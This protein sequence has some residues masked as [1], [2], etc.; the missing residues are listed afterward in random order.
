MNRIGRNIRRLREENGFS[1]E[2]IAFELGLTQTSYARLE[3]ADDRI[4]ITR[5]FKIAEVLNVCIHSLINDE[6][7]A[8]SDNDKE[9]ISL[10]KEE[11]AFLRKLIITDRT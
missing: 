10:L 7:P 1:Q 4:T 11:V 3:K 6:Y 8:N 5:L 2:A 9:I